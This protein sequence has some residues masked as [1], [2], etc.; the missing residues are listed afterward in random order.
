M[1]RKLTLLIALLGLCISFASAQEATKTFV[2]VH[3]AFQD[4]TAW[5]SVVPLLEAAGH[6]AIAIDLPAHGADET[7]DAEVTLAS[8]RD[9][10]IAV[11]EAQATPV[12]LV[13]HSFGGIV[14]S[15][16]AEAI[17]DQ[18][19]TLVYVAG[20]LPRN[21]DSLAGLA[22]LDHNNGFRETNFLLAEDYTYAYVL[23][24]DFLTIFCGDCTEEQAEVVMASRQNEPLAALNEPSTVTAEQFGTVRKVYIMTAED[25]AASPQIQAFMISQTPVDHVYALNTSHVPFVTMPE[26]LSALLISAAQ[27]E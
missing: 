22:A 9:A 7:P 11:I 6:T 16:V 8:Y 26:E 1:R 5:D 23:E 13:G 10:V 20:Y 18:V 12:V 17:P 15:E 3:G 4:S 21:G 2:L 19:E 14:I 24:E 25:N 27:G